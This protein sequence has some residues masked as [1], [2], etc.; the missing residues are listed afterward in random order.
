[1]GNDNLFK[2]LGGVK[3]NQE[4]NLD[5]YREAPSLFLGGDF[6]RF[7]Y[8]DAGNGTKVRFGYAALC[9]DLPVMSLVL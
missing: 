5:L 3:F 1:M 2:E 6:K 7:E 8:T 9:V 4:L